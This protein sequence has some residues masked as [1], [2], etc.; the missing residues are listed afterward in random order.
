M[1]T[2][3]FI[4]LA[5]CFLALLSCDKN[6]EESS[7]VLIIG[8]RPEDFYGL[9]LDGGYIHNLL[10]HVP[11]ESE[12]YVIHDPE[13]PFDNYSTMQLKLDFEDSFDKEKFMEENRLNDREWY[14]LKDTLKTYYRRR[15]AFIQK[16]LEN[17]DKNRQWF[18]HYTAYINGE[19]TVTCDKTLYGKASGENLAQYFKVEPK[20]WITP[21]GI[22]KTKLTCIFDRNSPKRINEFFTKETWTDVKYILRFDSIPEE[23]YDELK[24][25]V[26]MPLKLENTHKY[27]LNKLKGI[28][29]NVEMTDKTVSA[30]FTARFKQ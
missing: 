3:T 22:E 26:T 27:I 24:L 30:S 17:Y 25:T 5:L 2:K 23:K 15:T 12:A 21:R 18:L 6:E 8:S 16:E 13:A 9:M 7:N 1:K 20:A 14:E 11:P 10:I 29:E 19:V 28:D 4:L